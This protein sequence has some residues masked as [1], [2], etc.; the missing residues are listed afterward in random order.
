MRRAG[1]ASWVAMAT[2]VGSPAGALVATVV[3][4]L[5]RPAATLLW[6][7]SWSSARGARPR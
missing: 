6:T 5:G 4:S 7:P 2:V 1:T 3:G